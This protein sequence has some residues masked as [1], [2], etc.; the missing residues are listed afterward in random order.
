MFISNFNPS[1]ANISQWAA[2]IA[3][4]S[5]KWYLPTELYIV[6]FGAISSTA[7]TSFN[8]EE[9]SLIATA[10]TH[11]LHY[12]IESSGAVLSPHEAFLLALTF[13]M[14]IAVFP[15]VRLLRKVQQSPKPMIPATYSYC[16]IMLSIFLGVRPWLIAELGEDP[17]IWILK[18]MTS[19]EGYE[20]RLVIVSW[21]IA[22]LA[23]G[24]IVPIK[25]F[26]NTSDHDD[27]GELLN[28]RRKFFHGIVVLLFIP[29]LILDVYIFLERL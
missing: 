10:I 1:F 6:T 9:V 11:A 12:V 21:W 27:N 28:K 26:T 5:P 14:L 23:F 7:S 29:A 19:K 18:Y 15:A 4:V 3:I 20:L 17:T 24:I 2:V 8:F 13:G 22:V 16:I 25:F